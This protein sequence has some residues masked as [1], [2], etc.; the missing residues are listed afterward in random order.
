[1]KRI[2]EGIRRHC[3]DD[4]EPFADA[5]AELTKSGVKQM[6]ERAVPV[7][8]ATQVAERRGEPFLVKYYGTS[9]AKSVRSPMDTITAQGGKYALCTPYLLGQQ[10]QAVA[11]D[12]TAAPV[13]TVATRGAIG[14]YTP[15]AFIMP[16][17]GAYGGLHS[18]ATYKPEE[19]PL[20]TVTA[21]NTDGYLVRPYL[22]P[23]YGEREGQRP[24][25]HDIE[26]PLPTVT[27]TGSQPHVTMPY[28]VSYQGNDGSFPL[29]QPLPTVTSRDRFALVVPKMWPL[30]LDIRYRMLQPPELAAAMGFPPEYAFSGNKTETTK[31]IGNAVPVN[32]AKALTKQLLLNHQP[33]LHGYADE[34]VPADD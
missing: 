30:G 14:L 31:Q 33:D 5:V 18:N 16:R 3:D 32:T 29:D 1:M 10:S 27:A 22:V 21:K 9:T 23:Y 2:A 20:H 12:V 13:P 19:R 11:K 8:N 26:D 4:L 25:T 7:E 6:Q 28:L 24:R 15:G 17:N 34:E